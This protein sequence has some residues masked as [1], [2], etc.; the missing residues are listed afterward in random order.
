MAKELPNQKSTGGKTHKQHKDR[1]TT[2]PPKPTPK[3]K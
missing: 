2:L 1:N 3:S